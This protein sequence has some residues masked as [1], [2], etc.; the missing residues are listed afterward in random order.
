MQRCLHLAAA[1]ILAAFLANA[2]PGVA[3]AQQIDGR[4]LVVAR[5]RIRQELAEA[6]ANGG[7][8]PLKQ[9]NILL[10]AKETLPPE[11]VEGLEQTLLRLSALNRANG[12]ATPTIG[13]PIPSP[14]YQPATQ[15]PNGQATLTGYTAPADGTLRYDD[16]GATVTGGPIREDQP[17]EV[18]M[19]GWD[20]NA[21]FDGH[22]A[23]LLGGEDSF[24]ENMKSVW[25]QTWR[26]MSLF[27][28][29]EAFKGP[30]DLIVPNGNFG[31]RFGGN[32]G[33]PLAAQYGVGIQLGA[34]EELTDFNGAFSS[35][36]ILDTPTSDVRQQ[37]FVTVG[38]FQRLELHDHVIMWGFT[39]DWLNDDYY[40]TL[41]FAQ[42]RVKL[43]VEVNPCNELGIWAAM[44]DH[45]DSAPIS[46]GQGQ[47]FT[48]LDYRTLAQGSLYWKHTWYNMATTTTWV[49]LAQEPG[50][51]VIGSDARLPIAKRLNLIGSFNAI[52]PRAT[53]SNGQFDELWNVSLGIEL[54][55][56]GVRHCPE[57]R[58]SPVLPVA[59]NGNMAVRVLA[60]GL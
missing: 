6:L 49:G 59:D 56:G 29:I 38:L 3:C 25:S 15:A 27:S 17:G 55:P 44:P 23:G 10:H 41:H 40:T 43:G 13:A 9:Y 16:P 18:A 50:I 60:N 34:S 1:A 21:V 35:T 46:L 52:L 31:M 20:D 7:L 33:I 14:G 12:P 32:A 37:T 5:Q 8:T 47:P 51:V 19:E 24:R 4:K 22:E 57:Y 26:N 42:W 2:I 39:H 45:G 48:T 11:D 30:E 54:V 28:T 58:F 53:G 36:G